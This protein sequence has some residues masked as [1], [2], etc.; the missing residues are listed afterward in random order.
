MTLAAEKGFK[1]AANGTRRRPTAEEKTAVEKLVRAEYARNKVSAANLKALRYQNLTALDVDGDGAAE[2]VGS[3]WVAAGDKERDLLFFI[4]RK[5][6][7][8]D[9][10]FGYSEFS[11][12]TPDD[13]MSSEL[14]DMDGGIGHEL[15]IDVLDVD[16][17]G[18]AEIFTIAKAFE[19]DNFHAYKLA[20]GKW[21]RVF[22]TYNYRCAY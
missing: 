22:E 21:T 17:D 5:G 7:G 20:G 6:S 2:F 10:V 19:G 13:V 18:T 12:V 3:Y 9:L 11:K 16:G 1:L 15:L 8:G 14:K 4:A